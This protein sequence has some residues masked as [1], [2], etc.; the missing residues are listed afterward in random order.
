MASECS[1]ACIE[2]SHSTLLVGK[3]STETDAR[4]VLKNDRVECCG[5]SWTVVR[6]GLKLNGEELATIVT[7]MNQEQETGRKA[8]RAVQQGFSSV[9]VYLSGQK[10][11]IT[12]IPESECMATNERSIPSLSPQF[13]LIHLRFMQQSYP[14]DFLKLMSQCSATDVDT[15]SVVKKYSFLAVDGRI[16]EAAMEEIL[17][18]VSQNSD[19]SEGLARLSKARPE[20]KIRPSSFPP[21]KD[22]IAYLKHHPLTRNTVPEDIGFFESVAEAFAGGSIEIVS[23]ADWFI[24]GKISEFSRSL[25]SLGIDSTQLAQNCT[26]AL[27]DFAQGVTVPP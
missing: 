16:Y 24:G 12:L 1:S 21:L 23:E 2:K 26:K 7:A 18:A 19:L 3:S 6:D 5:R 10:K 25:D 9:T 27:R 20:K 17:S 11:P 13:L 15:E 14:S 22:L 8:S 4:A